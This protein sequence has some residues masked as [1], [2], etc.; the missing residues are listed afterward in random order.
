MA[1]L[2]RD[3]KGYYGV[4]GLT[5]RADTAAIKRAYRSRAKLLHPDRNPSPRAVAEFQ[6]L[7]EAYRVLSD[8]EARTLY[9]RAPLPAAGRVGVPGVGQHG[10]GRRHGLAGGPTVARTTGM[11]TESPLAPHACQVCGRVTAQPRYLVLHRV[12]GLGFR[13][14]QRP[15]SGIFCRLHGHRTAVAASLYCW[16]LG[17][18]AI[19]W[20]PVRTLQALWRNLPGGQQPAAENHQLLMHQARAF[21]ARGNLP[22]ARALAEQGLGFARTDEQR[23]HARRILEA[24]ADQ[25]RLRPRD[26]GPWLGTAVLAH[27]APLLLLGLLALYVAGPTRVIGA[28]VTPLVALWSERTDS[29]QEAISAPRTQGPFTGTTRPAPAESRPPTDAPPTEAPPADPFASTA[30]PGG[31][32]ARPAPGGA[33]PKEAD[34]PIEAPVIGHL[35]AV[36]TSAVVVRS[37]PGE[38]YRVLATVSQDTVLMVTE[39]SPDGL[40]GRVLSARGI[41]GFVPTDSLRPALADAVTR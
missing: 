37:G 26:Q 22:L 29:T 6:F 38:G 20:G 10:R 32:A 27:L 23:Q 28:M 5:P 30:P 11:A 1:A 7:N 33:K 12:R 8:P 25:P 39:L 2:V 18:W 40:W 13:T 14:E 41:S 35:Y 24:L 17:W 16:A 21:L 3:P 19:P 9:D 31:T 36:R 4:L 34:R 15:I